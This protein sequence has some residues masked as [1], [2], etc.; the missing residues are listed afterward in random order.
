MALQVKG[1]YFFLTPSFTFFKFNSIINFRFLHQIG[2]TN[3]RDI[4]QE[5]PVYPTTSCGEDHNPLYC[6]WAKYELLAPKLANAQL[7]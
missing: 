4:S 1:Q 5:F 3:V 2:L 7:L 6:P